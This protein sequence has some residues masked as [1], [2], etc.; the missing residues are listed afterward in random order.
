MKKTT[1]Y[2]AVLFSQRFRNRVYEDVIKAVEKSAEETGVSRSDIARDLGFSKSHISRLLSGPSN[3]TLD[4][5]SNLLFSVGAE[6]KTEAVFFADQPKENH[7]HVL[8]ESPIRSCKTWTPVRPARATA[9]SVTQPVVW[10]K[11]VLEKC[12]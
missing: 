12:Q 9:K 3:W 8:G 2:Q 6:L 4:T 10:N 11:R 5:L 1:N 7:F